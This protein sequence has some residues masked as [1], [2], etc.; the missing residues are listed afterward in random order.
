MFYNNFLETNSYGKHNII[1]M[2]CI[3]GQ[4]MFLLDGATL[5]ACMEMA[6]WK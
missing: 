3:C 1:S 5:N 2:T 6:L 4:L